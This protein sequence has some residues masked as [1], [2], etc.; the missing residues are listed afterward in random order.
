MRKKREPPDDIFTRIKTGVTTAA[1]SHPQNAGSVFL[2]KFHLH[3]Q[4]RS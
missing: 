2:L 4:K 1:S 3:H